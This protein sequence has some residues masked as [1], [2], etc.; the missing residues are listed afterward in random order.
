MSDN[1][2]IRHRDGAVPVTPEDLLAS[3]AVSYW[4]KDALRAALSRDPLDAA[5]DAEL[6]AHVLGAR[7]DAILA[8]DMARLGLRAQD[9]A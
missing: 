9:C 8:A 1:H 6:L 2:P 4:L 5:G 7:A 3:P